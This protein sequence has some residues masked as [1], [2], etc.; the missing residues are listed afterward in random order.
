MIQLRRVADWRV[1]LNDVFI[2]LNRKPF[3]W[4]KRDCVTGFGVPVV[5]ALTGENLLPEGIASYTD[6]EGAK[7]AL[8]GQGAESLSDWLSQR[9]PSIPSSRA[10]TGDL[11]IIPAEGI[12]EGLGAYTGDRIGVLTPRG[13]GTIPRNIYESFKIG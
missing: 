2:G 5:L 4:W 9:L 13:Y 12:G 10:R 7:A 1:R 6:A 3:V 8:K 11:C